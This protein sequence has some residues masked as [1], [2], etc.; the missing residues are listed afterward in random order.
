MNA[1]LTQSE[2][3]RFSFAFKT[4]NHSLTTFYQT[5]LIALNKILTLK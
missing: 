1:I 5:I 2:P 3:K 4:S